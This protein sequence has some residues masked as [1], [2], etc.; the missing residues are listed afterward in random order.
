[1]QGVGFRATCQ[2]ISRRHEV[3]GWVRN[4]PDGAV[5]LA[6]EGEPEAVENFLEAIAGEMSFHIRETSTHDEPPRGERGFRVEH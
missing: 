1:M 5:E 4:Q 2:S 3:S 6:A